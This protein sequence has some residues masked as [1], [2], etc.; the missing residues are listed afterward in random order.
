M[1]LTSASQFVLRVNGVATL[2]SPHRAASAT[3][4]RSISAARWGDAKV[5]TPFTRNTN[6]LAEVNRILNSYI[7]QRTTNVIN[8]LKGDG[9]YP[10]FGAPVFNQRGGTVAPGFQ[11][12][13]T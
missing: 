10:A 4:A 12:T 6:W 2:A 7:P 13:I 9:L 5:A 11:L 1:R 8:Q 3:T